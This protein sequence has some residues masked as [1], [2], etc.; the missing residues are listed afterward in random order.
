MVH[1]L[2]ETVGRVYVADQYLN[3]HCR[4]G[5]G[6]FRGAA[7]DLRR[8]RPVVVQ[9]RAA[10]DRNPSGAG[11]GLGQ[12]ATVGNTVAVCIYGFG[13]DSFIHRPDAV[14]AFGTRLS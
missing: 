9:S 11:I 4:P 10:D 1:S 2:P 7:L 8:V 5:P 3:C 14:F 6:R 12:P 13:D